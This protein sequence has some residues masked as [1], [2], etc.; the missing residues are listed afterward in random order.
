MV[1]R[2][3]STYR[4]SSSEIVASICTRGPKVLAVDGQKS[5]LFHL[6]LVCQA[7]CYRQVVGR[8]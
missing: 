5:I 7:I 4:F 3:H 6:T 8:S 1:H 2:F